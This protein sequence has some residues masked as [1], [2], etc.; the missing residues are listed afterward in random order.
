MTNRAIILDGTAQQL[1]A[2]LGFATCRSVTIENVV[3]NSVMFWGAKEKQLMTLAAGTKISLPVT[4]LKNVWILG[5]N[6]DVVNIA[7]FG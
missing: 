1:S 7:V 5:T 4:N 2:L 3:G 6:T